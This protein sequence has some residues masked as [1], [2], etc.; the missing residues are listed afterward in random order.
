M[1]VRVANFNATNKYISGVPL[2]FIISM[3]CDVRKIQL[4][5]RWR[6]IMLEIDHQTSE[7]KCWLERMAWIELVINALSQFGIFPCV[8]YIVFDH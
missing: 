3:W 1:L 2:C 4:R 7:K 5:I 6:H 8:I